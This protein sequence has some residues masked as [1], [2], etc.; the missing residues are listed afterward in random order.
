MQMLPIPAF[1]LSSTALLLNLS[2]R[3]SQQQWPREQLLGPWQLG[4]PCTV[5]QISSLLST[6]EHGRGMHQYQFT[7]GLVATKA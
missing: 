4:S 3:H 6:W 1:R 5:R 7:V 2:I